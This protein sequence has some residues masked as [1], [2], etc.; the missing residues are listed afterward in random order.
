MKVKLLKK[1]RKR[2]KYQI[3]KG[4]DSIVLMRWVDTKTWD[5]DH[6]E[7]SI[8]FTHVIYNWMNTMGMNEYVRQ[9]K[10]DHMARRDIQRITKQIKFLKERYGI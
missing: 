5:E 8:G 6:I 1:L 10:N 7:S 3:V 2:F 9:Y 4:N